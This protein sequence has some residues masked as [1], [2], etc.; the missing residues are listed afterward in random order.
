MMYVPIWKWY[1]DGGVVAGPKP[2]VARARYNIQELGPP[3][4]LFFNEEKLELFGLDDL[5]SFPPLTHEKIRCSELRDSCMELQL[6][7]I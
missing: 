7:E 3:L 6:V 1:I 4:C 2:A 5:I